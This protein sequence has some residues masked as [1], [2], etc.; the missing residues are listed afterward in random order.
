MTMREL[1]SLCKV[2]VS[3]VSKAFQDSKEISAETKERILTMAKQYGCLGKYQKQKYRKPIIA[4]ICHEVQSNYY[5][6]MVETLQR[7]IQKSGCI[8]TISTDHFD[9]DEQE[10]LIEYYAS[11]MKVDG[12]LVLGLQTPVKNGYEIPVVSLLSSLGS[13]VDEISLD[14]AGGIAKA[15]DALYRLGHR[16][17]AFFGENLTEYKAAFFHDSA[18]RYK[19]LTPIIFKSELRFEPAGEDC[20]LRMLTE[21]AD[22]TA[23][24]CGYDNIAFGAIKALKQKGVAI[25]KDFSIIGCDNLK[26]GKYMDLALSTMG[27]DEDELCHLAWDL[28]QRKIKN[29]YYRSKQHI[30][31]ECEIFLRDTVA[32]KKTER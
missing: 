22:C 16:K 8:A 17:I 12:I 7:L 30:T 21:H 27:A 1:A 9:K 3:T 10:E 11:Y 14:L 4:I 15:V 25:P 24:V 5:S 26:V 19:D 31:L 29:K 20:A 23:A 28:L 13:N 32:T 2:S 6:S 18:R